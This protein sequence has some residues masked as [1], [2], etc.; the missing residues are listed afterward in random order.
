MI[1]IG[2]AVISQVVMA[3]LE[4]RWNR[5]AERRHRDVRALLEEWRVRR[6]PP[7]DGGAGTAPVNP[8]GSGLDPTAILDVTDPQRRAVLM[9]EAG[10][11]AM[12]PYLQRYIRS[13]LDGA[14]G[15]AVAELVDVHEP[16]AHGRTARFI[17]R[18]LRMVD[19]TT[20]RIHIEGVPN[21]MQTIAE[22]LN[23]RAGDVGRS[24]RPDQHT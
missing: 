11:T 16:F 13:R 7:A 3:V 4:S 17:G 2:L 10:M 5:L 21:E 1:L 8:D 20:R 18:Y 6:P 23:W 15:W 14:D 22:A 19:P 9:A 12:Y 24:W